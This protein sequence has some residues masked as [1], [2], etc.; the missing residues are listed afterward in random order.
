MSKAVYRILVAM[1]SIVVLFCSYILF[2]AVVMT[3]RVS[4][5]SREA[6]ACDYARPK[7]LDIDKDQAIQLVNQHFDMSYI[8]RIVDLDESLFGQSIVPISLVLL[9]NNLNSTQTIQTL[10]HELCHIK[11]YTNNETY[12]EYMTF[13]ELYESDNE[14]LKNAAEWMI[15]EHLVLHANYGTAYDISYYIAE[16]LGLDAH[17]VN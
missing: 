3:N 4:F 16:Y 8:L 1:L 17:V 15:Y 13:V 5:E 2:S 9:D 12:T 7:F 6:V 14:Y 11:Y 10:A